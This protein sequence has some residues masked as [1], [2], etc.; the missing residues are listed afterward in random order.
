MHFE[1]L[2]LI[3]GKKNIGTMVLI[4]AFTITF[5]YFVYENYRKQNEINTMEKSFFNSNNFLLSKLKSLNDKLSVFKR[6]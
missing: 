5:A 6:S 2:L 3:L 4:G 1:Q